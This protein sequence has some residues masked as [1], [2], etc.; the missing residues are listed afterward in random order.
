MLVLV[1]CGRM[2]FSDITLDAA[3]TT[4]RDA[5]GLTTTDGDVLPSSWQ[6]APVQPS[7]TSNLWALHA[8]SATDI[9]VAG[10]TG[11]IARW[12]GSSWTPS[13][14]NETLTL[15]ILWAAAQDNLW[16]VGEACTLLRYQGVSWQ[17]MLV[18]GCTGNKALNSIDGTTTSNVWVAGEQGTILQY[19]GST[20]T[21]R[22]QGNLSYWD[23][24]VESA[25][26]TLVSG[27]LGT[28]LR[29]NGSM[30]VNEAGSP[31]AT[32]AAITKAGNE[33]WM[34]GGMG[35]IIHKIGAGTWTAQQSPVTSGTLYGVY[36]AATN[37][38]WAVG[39][40]GVILHYNGSAW[41]QVQSP[42]TK[43]LR[44]ISGIPGGGMVATGDTGVVLIHP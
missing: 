1:G 37:D 6:L 8:F 19:N 31:T 11:Y 9:W 14:S 29:W 21:D 44:N 32:L 34:V 35:T 20:W 17:P 15:F 18:N 2:G 23:V 13:A 4:D 10:T 25:T 38:V 36:A 5:E 22:S 39:T 41:A 43:T 26:D 7:T 42:T 30:M 12:N 28:I 27:T 33:S 16:L 3:A 40:A 24:D